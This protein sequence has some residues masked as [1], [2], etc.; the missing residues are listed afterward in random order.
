MFTAMLAVNNILGA[1]VDLWSINTDQTY[2]E[3]TTAAEG[4]IRESITKLDATQPLVP[5]TIS[6]PGA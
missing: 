6:D 1:S 2:H 4:R 3:E 5:V